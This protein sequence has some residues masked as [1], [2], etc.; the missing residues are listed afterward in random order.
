M[1]LL[2]HLVQGQDGCADSMGDIYRRWSSH[3]VIRIVI[4][5]IRNPKEVGMAVAHRYQ[6]WRGHK[7]QNSAVSI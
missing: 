6:K 3:V 2:P 7:D 1:T 4:P 5:I